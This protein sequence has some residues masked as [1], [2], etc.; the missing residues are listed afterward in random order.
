MNSMAAVDAVALQGRLRLVLEVEDMRAV[1][2]SVGIGGSIRELSRAQ[3]RLRELERVRCDPAR[4]AHAAKWRRSKHAGLLVL[5]DHNGVV[6]TGLNNLLDRWFN[7]SSPTAIGF[8]GVSSNTTAVTA[9][10]VNLNGASGGTAAN[11][12]IKAISPAATRSSQTVTGGAT[13]ANADFTSGVFVINKV[14]F[15]TTSTDAGTGLIDVIGGTGGSDPYSR[16]FS[17]DFTNAG[18]FTLIPQIAL[19]AV[20]VR[21]SFPSPL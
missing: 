15:L 13:F 3:E 20:A 14:G 10:T 11:T 21:G 2:A 18:T 12:I 4:Y 6:N 17:V 9:T 5:E 19:T 7:L 1:K 16:T 8:I